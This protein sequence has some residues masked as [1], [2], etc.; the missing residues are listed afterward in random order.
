MMREPG[1]C[2]IC[3][4]AHTACT[5]VGPAGIVIDQLPARTELAQTA[6]PPELPAPVAFSTAT[7]DRTKHKPKGR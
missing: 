5:A 1:P 4:A 6:P 2:P 3:G 7:Y